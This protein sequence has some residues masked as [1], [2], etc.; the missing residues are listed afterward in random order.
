MKWSVGAKIA[1]GF[2]LTLAILL[3]I[4]GVSYRSIV[5]LTELVALGGPHA[6]GSGTA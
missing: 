4:G 5:N 6:C 2:G 3:V 1:S